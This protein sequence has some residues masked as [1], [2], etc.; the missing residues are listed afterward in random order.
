M[1]IPRFTPDDLKKLPL[2][3]IVALALRTARRVEHLALLP[4]DHPQKEQCR[5]AVANAIGLA[6]DFA[7]GLPCMAPEAAVREIEACRTAA[8]GDYERASAMGAVV[9]AAHAAAT[10]M[11]ALALRAEPDQPHYFGFHEPNP[12]PHL[13]DI[14]ADLAA[15][16]AFLA[17]MEAAGGEEYA[18]AFVR[19]SAD[20][21]AKLLQ[22][23][24]GSYPQAGKPIDPSS[25]GPLGP[26]EGSRN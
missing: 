22:L 19:A 6:E 21:Y 12:F 9:M 18:D 4:D 23:D 14:T 20:D 10:A 2:R 11:H 26:L 5:S 24:L 25:N 17:G 7:K 16:E 15:R 3:A 8:D 1:I 13:A